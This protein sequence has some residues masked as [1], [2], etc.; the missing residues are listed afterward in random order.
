MKRRC[1][2]HKIGGD[3]AQLCTVHYESDMDRVGMASLECE[4]VVDQ[5]DAAGMAVLAEL[6]LQTDEG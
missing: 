5:L 2:S 4:T 6:P 1:P 3:G